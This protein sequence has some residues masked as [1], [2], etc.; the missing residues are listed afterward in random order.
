MSPKAKDEKRRASPRTSRAESALASS[1]AALEAEL[2]RFEELTALARRLPLAS[3]KHIERAAAALAEAVDSQQRVAE[4]LHD[5]TQAIVSARERH[6]AA[7]V[8]AHER[9]EEIN[10][11]REEL[12][13]LVSRFEALGA[14]A[15]RLT[16]SLREGPDGKGPTLPHLP[17][18]PPGAASAAFVDLAAIQTELGELAAEADTLAAAAQEADADALARQADSLRQQLHATKNKLALLEERIGARATGRA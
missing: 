2:Q 3:Q 1:A 13:A 14:R 15:A 10:R 6:D 9:A 11:R 5:L 4:R 16:A 12:G 18:A 8:T 7:V 17:G